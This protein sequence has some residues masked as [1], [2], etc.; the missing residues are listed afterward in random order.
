MAIYL[1]SIT[2]TI[3]SFFHLKLFQRMNISFK[4]LRDIKHKL[5]TEYGEVAQWHLQPGPDGG[6][7]V[8]NDTTI[9]D[10]ANRIIHET[11]NIASITNQN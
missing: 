6:I 1:P 10:V 7:M 3:K 8:I 5:P 11:Q 4:D 2:K 9:L